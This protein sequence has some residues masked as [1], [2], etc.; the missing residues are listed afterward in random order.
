MRSNQIECVSSRGPR[1]TTHWRIDMPG[2]THVLKFSVLDEN[3][4]NKIYDLD[5]K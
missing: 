5:E 1:T 4:M 3:I 2:K